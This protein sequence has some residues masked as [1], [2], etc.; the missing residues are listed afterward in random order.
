MA[1]WDDL[2]K[3]TNPWIAIG[4]AVAVPVLV[5]LVSRLAA[6]AAKTV[7]DATLAAGG[8]LGVAVERT[9]EA[10]IKG[11]YRGVVDEAIDRVTGLLAAAGDE[12]GDIV[13]EARHEYQTGTGWLSRRPSQ[14]T[15]S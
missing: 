8:T 10:A 4:A 9:I 6:P 14:T 7:V 11:F 3:G 15:P 13:A 2:V 5:P 12:L 1:F